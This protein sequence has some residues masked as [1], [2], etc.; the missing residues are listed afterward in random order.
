MVGIERPKMRLF[1]AELSAQEDIM[2]DT[3]A[4]DRGDV[5]S[6]LEAERKDTFV[7]GRRKDKKPKFDGFK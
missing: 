5:G 4:M 6:R 3:P 7:T 1:D 2:D